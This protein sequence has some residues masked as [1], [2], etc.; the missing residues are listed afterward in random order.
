M[1]PIMVTNNEAIE[2]FL[3]GKRNLAAYQ[4]SQLIGEIASPT[5]A[6]HN[7]SPSSF[8]S[9]PSQATTPDQVNSDD[10][11]TTSQYSDSPNSQQQQPAGSSSE[12]AKKQQP[13]SDE[14]A[15]NYAII[16]LFTGCPQKAST[17]FNDLVK[18]YPRNPRL[19]LRL[20]ESMLASERSRMTE[21]EHVQQLTDPHSRDHLVRCKSKPIL[22]KINPNYCQ[23][24]MQQ[25][26]Q[27]QRKTASNFL[28]KVQGY[29]LKSLELI[30][31]YN[32]MSL[33]TDDIPSPPTSVQQQSQ[34]QLNSSN[35]RRNESS[36]A[37]TTTSTSSVTSSTSILTDNPGTNVVHDDAGLKLSQKLSY[38]HPYQSISRSDL[39]HL[40]NKVQLNLA[41]VSLCMGE[42]SKAL[43]YTTQCLKSSPL[44][45]ERVLANLYHAEAC[46]L[47][48]RVDEAIQFLN[49]EVLNMTKSLSQE[50]PS[51]T[52]KANRVIY[53]DDMQRQLETGALTT[54]VT[55]N[56]SVAYAAKGDFSNAQKILMRSIHPTEPN[57]MQ[58]IICMLYI[59]LQQGQLESAK[60]TILNNLPQFR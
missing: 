57:P 58:I 20:A 43:N 29:L 7:S 31:E 34:Q 27:I 41:Y 4:F 33:L 60:R 49:L 13:N 26:F 52:G 48:G 9:Y 10:I 39:Y 40:K 38:A 8:A 22:I 2:N 23:Q 25:Q 14:I 24:Q 55:Y 42:P 11:T 17:I 28:V 15:F 56:L 36:L 44:G 21:Y 54:V 30:N 51:V 1:H 59:Q 5:R 18:R 50:H 37:P 46:I 19:W 32:D 12:A 3:N 47:A 16:N 53:G 6:P 35:A 45:Y